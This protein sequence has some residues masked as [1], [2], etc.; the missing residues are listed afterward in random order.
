MTHRGWWSLALCLLAGVAIILMSRF[1]SSPSDNGGSATGDMNSEIGTVESVKKPPESPSGAP[2]PFS[3]DTTAVDGKSA[4]ADDAAGTGETDADLTAAVTVNDSSTLAKEWPEVDIYNLGRSDI[5]DSDFASLAERLNADPD[6]LQA[7]INEFRLETDVDRLR[8]LAQL[9]GDVNLPE[10]TTL[11]SE[12]IFSG[13]P[14]SRKVGLELLKYIQP[15]NSDAHSLVS[16]LLTTEYGPE[17]LVDTLT[18]LAVPGTVDDDTRA[19]LS[20]QVAVLATHQD[21]NVRRSSID[22]LSRWSEDS[23][24]TPIILN[25]LQDENRF[26]RQTSA[27]ALVGHEDESYEVIQSLMAVA[28]DTN[29]VERVRRGSILALKGMAIDDATKNR[30]ATIERQLNTR[31]P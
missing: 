9:L 15:G 13:D 3:T 31:Q 7:I 18:A 22:I 20:D 14:A 6:F 12:M 28:S 1:S 17:V 27:Y 29:E 10:V 16:G 26:V 30:L 25:G 24:H 23:V 11:A 21:A 2:S 19:V 4:E 8:R 5:S